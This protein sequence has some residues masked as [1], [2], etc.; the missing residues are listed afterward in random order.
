M[1]NGEDWS[2][3]QAS[4]A[5]DLIGVPIPLRTGRTPIDDP[6]GGPSLPFRQSLTA[7]A[8]EKL[9]QFQTHALEEIN[10][11]EHRQARSGDLAMLSA[12]AK[13]IQRYEREAWRRFNRSI[14]QLT[15]PAPA[16]AVAVEVKPE[17]H[18]APTP[19]IKVEPVKDVEADDD[20][21]AFEVTRAEIAATMRELGIEGYPPGLDVYLARNQING[22]NPICGEQEVGIEAGWN[23]ASR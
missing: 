19:V 14:G 21:A 15:A 8:I 18:V 10:E 11:L 3:D 13:L 12:P 16:V 23:P 17:P 9:E 7:H 2:E 1:S 6:E 5:L 20:A 4:L 22:T